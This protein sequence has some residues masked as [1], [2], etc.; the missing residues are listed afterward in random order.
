MREY[1]SIAETLSRSSG[2]AASV[3]FEA[4]VDKMDKIRRC[5]TLWSLRRLSKRS[6][7][8]ELR[9]R[10]QS[11]TLVEDPNDEYSSSESDLSG[12]EEVEYD[13]DDSDGWGLPQRPAA[14]KGA[15]PAGP[16]LFRC[17]LP[18]KAPLPKPEA[19][20]GEGAPA[21]G[22][23]AAE[24]AGE[25]QPKKKRAKKEQP[26][27][28]ADGARDPSG[29][30]VDPSG[31][32]ATATAPAAAAKASAPAAAA[33][34]GKGRGKGAGKG[35]KQPSP[36]AEGVAEAAPPPAAAETA[37]RGKKRA[38]ATAGNAV[39]A[40]AAPTDG[41]GAK[42]KGGRKKAAVVAAAAA[43]PSAGGAAAAAHAADPASDQGQKGKGKRKAAG[44]AKGEAASAAAPA[45]AEGAAPDAAAAA[46]AAAGAAAAG[47]CEGGF[48][49]S[50]GV[51]TLCGG[52][53]CP[54]C[55]CAVLDRAL[56]VCDPADVKS[57]ETIKRETQ[58]CPTCFGAIQKSSGCDQMVRRAQQRHRFRPDASGSHHFS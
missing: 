55:L 45:A 7:K 41:E 33:K 6:A 38:A 57:A 43:E 21:L 48:L 24:G 32:A 26:A 35:G 14:L 16:R 36:A 22:E 47:T 18:A 25:Q 42:K 2:A 51:C 5:L 37:K 23:Q 39:V 9:Q 4:R 49:L 34:P 58:S 17:Q 28:A 56:H 8:A 13:S 29:A 12:A 20:T 52:R 30:Q 19:A 15:G 44:A 40:E 3:R 1:I 46:S 54:K 53:N 50:D 27:A 31:A 11:F 10:L